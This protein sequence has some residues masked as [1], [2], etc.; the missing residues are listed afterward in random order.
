MNSKI[1]SA[2]MVSMSLKKSHL[3]QPQFELLARV[4]SAVILIPFFLWVTH[5]GGWIFYSVLTFVFICA[6]REWSR[7]STNSIF[8]PFCLAALIGLAIY[9]CSVDVT[10]IKMVSSL[11][12]I[13]ALYFQYPTLALPSAHRWAI[14]LGGLCYITASVEC[15]VQ[16]SQYSAKSPLFLLWLYGIVWATDSGAYLIGKTIK[17][18]KLCPRIS[19]NK[20]WSGFIGGIVTAIIVG[21]YLLKAFE[22]SLSST[23]PTAALICLLSLAGHSGDLIESLVKRYFGVKNAGDLIP[24]HG[25]VL[26]R[27]DSLFLVIITTAFLLLFKII[28]I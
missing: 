15:F 28:H 3:M 10:Y 4:L 27:L 8:H 23:I 14:F 26:D 7:L 24:G 21:Q 1:E 17:G 18:P 20:T 13:G 5:T 2:A 6:L 25:G 16:I 12:F 19:P 9:H 11:V 22:I